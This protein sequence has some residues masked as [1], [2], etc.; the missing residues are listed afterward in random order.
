MHLHLPRRT[1]A[2]ATGAACATAV[3]A[4]AWAAATA[5]QLSLA[6]PAND[7]GTAPDI[8][9]V[10]VTS[11]DTGL[12]RFRVEIPNRPG[13]LPDDDLFLI[14]DADDDGTTGDHGW[15]FQV[16]VTAAGAELVRFDGEDDYFRVPLGRRSSYAYGGSGFDLVLGREA[17]GMTAGFE[18]YAAARGSASGEPEELAPDGDE[19]WWFPLRLPYDL[20][21]SPLRSRFDPADTRP[22][23]GRAWSLSL[24]AVR[25]DTG[26][27]L[28]VGT[29]SCSGRLG[30][31]ALPQ[32][33]GRFVRILI[34]GLGDRTTAVCGGW[35]LP[36]GARGK[37]V[38]ATITVSHGGKSL[39][40]TLTGRAG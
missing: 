26:A 21:V 37:Q 24:R 15:D 13:L 4:S 35:M 5:N 11:D 38:S 3:V 18:F 27:P 12:V 28:A 29:V 31:K 16:R 6:D 36:K 30:A 10:S 9:A 23:A 17:L 33:R 14:I 1:V 25:A 32:R 34:P 2:L 22:R 39:S 7:S 40:R 19:T 8:T 20:Y